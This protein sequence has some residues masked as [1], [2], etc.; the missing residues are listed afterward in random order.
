[1]IH[2]V[3]GH[4]KAI[5][6]KTFS[7]LSL[8]CVIHISKSK[9]KIIKRNKTFKQMKILTGCPTGPGGPL[10]PRNPLGPLKR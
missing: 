3:H 10:D 5:C 8:A 1:M 4:F 6:L 7:S 9:Y 2:I